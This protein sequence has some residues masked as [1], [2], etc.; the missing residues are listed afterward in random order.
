MNQIVRSPQKSSTKGFLRLAM[1]FSRELLSFVAFLVACSMAQHCPEPFGE[2]AYPHPQL[3]DH[4]IRCE[5]GTASIGVCENGLLFDGKGNVHDHCNYHWAVECGDRLAELVPIN[6]PGCEFKFGVYPESA[7]C[8]SNYIKCA[9]GVP[10]Q[11]PCEP[12]LVYDHRIHGCNWPDEM[13]E[14]CNPEAI[15][16]FRC[17]EKVPAHSPAARFWPY[18][19]FP[20]PGDCSKLITCVNG[21][22]RLIT[23]GEGKLFDAETLT[24][25]DPENVPKCGNFVK[26]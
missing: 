2:Q 9:H 25:D 11:T 22:P 7:A 10:Y 20:V 14:T 17:P 24:C 4:F 1:P 21:H 16:G 3:C 26:K 6:A 13:L 19:R 8:S 15:I 12:G 23:C 18:P 5:N